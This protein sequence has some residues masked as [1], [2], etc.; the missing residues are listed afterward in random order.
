MDAA[1]A[2]PTFERVVPPPAPAWAWAVCAAA[3]LLYGGYL[4][5]LIVLSVAR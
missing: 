3:G 4:T 5:F 2:G 1:A